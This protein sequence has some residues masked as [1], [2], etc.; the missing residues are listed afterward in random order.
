MTILLIM[1]AAGLVILLMAGDLL[2]RGAVGLAA[3]LRIPPLIVGLTIVAFGTSAPELVVTIKAVLSGSSGIAIGNIIGSNI[4]NVLL[5]LGAPALI[6]PIRCATEGLDLDAT[7]MLA[8]TAFFSAIAYAVGAIDFKLGLTLLVL[9]VSFVAYS[10]LRAARGGASAIVEDPQEIGGV[11]R[12][13]MKTAALLVV[14]LVGLPLGAG[15]LVDNGGEI[16]RRMA[17][18]EELI[19]LTIVAFGTSLPELSTV[20][21]AALRKQSD[22][23]L[24]NVVGSNIFNLLAVGGAAGVAGGAAFDVMSLHFDIPVM[25]AAATLVAAYIWGNRT[26]GRFSG[27]V[28]TGLYLGYVAVLASTA[29][30]I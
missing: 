14:G 4:A 22:V 23:A 27:F 20:V 9:I 18:R 17:V 15:L 2:V 25:A 19:G 8:A 16:A 28:F 13:P 5:V 12:E 11:P 7:I 29:Q 30:I 10:G 1:V 21:S 26:L 6:Y 24:G 3:L